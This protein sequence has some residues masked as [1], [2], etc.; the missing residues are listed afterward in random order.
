MQCTDNTKKKKP[1]G[2]EEVALNCAPIHQVVL[3]KIPKELQQSY[4]RKYMRNKPLNVLV[5]SYVKSS[6]NQLHE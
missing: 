5:Y 6:A 3:L 1:T 4:L 2:L